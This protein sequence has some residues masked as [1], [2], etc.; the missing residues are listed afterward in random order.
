[1]RPRLTG[2]RTASLA[3]NETCPSPKARTTCLAT[4]RAVAAD[5]TRR[6]VRQQGQCSD[7]RARKEVVRGVGWIAIGSRDR[8][9]CDGV[10]AVGPR[11]EDLLHHDPDGAM[12]LIV[13]API[14]D[15]PLATL[16]HQAGLDSAGVAGT[17]RLHRDGPVGTTRVFVLHTDDYAPRTPSG[18][19][20]AWT[21]GQ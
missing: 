19:A 18:S 3:Q 2:S 10:V 17:I 1:M 4:L 15:F 7:H 12:G 20:A 6:L 9:E 5:P 11:G 13:N 8:G 21:K 14:G 16:Q